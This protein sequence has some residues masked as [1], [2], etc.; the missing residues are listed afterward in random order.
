MVDV[1]VV[2]F[3]ESNLFRERTYHWARG[4]SGLS[5]VAFFG[6]NTWS[7]GP[8]SENGMASPSDDQAMSDRRSPKR[9]WHSLKS[10]MFFWKNRGWMT[11]LSFSI[12]MVPFFC[13]DMLNFQGS[14]YLQDIRWRRSAFHRCHRFE[15]LDV[16]GVL[17]YL[18]RE[19]LQ[20]VAW[21]TVQ[22]GS[23][24]FWGGGG[25]FSLGRVVVLEL[26]ISSK[27]DVD[28][29]LQKNLNRVHGPV[30]RKLII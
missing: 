30:E 13:T 7:F 17:D 9:W 3:C 18:L 2:F 23:R 16:P 6:E 24:A 8:V 25:K 26:N 20:E 29:T 15:A 27:L 22:G 21:Q 10:N 28:L 4:F 14:F 1:F 5:F 19:L 11:I 12:D